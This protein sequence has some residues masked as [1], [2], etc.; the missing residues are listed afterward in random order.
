ML[1]TVV[2]PWLHYVAVIVM[3]GALMSQ[4]YLLKLKPTLESVRALARVDRIFGIAA[5]A[6][7]ITGFSRIPVAHG[8]KGMAFY[9]KN[10]AFHAT[11]TL[12]VI[13]VLISL[14]PTF[15]YIRYKK[16]AEAGT[17]PNEAAWRANGKFVHIG[18][19]IIVLLA[20][21]MTMMARGV[22]SFS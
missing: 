11:L 14:I 13:G 8:G 21:T 19:T 20:A 15:R 1:N 7:L 22:G 18:L 9:M 16:A 4:L 17:L 2:I 12:F 10:G 5:L 3:S 6:V